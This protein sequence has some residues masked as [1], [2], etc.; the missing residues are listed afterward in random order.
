MFNIAQHGDTD[1]DFLVS[2]DTILLAPLPNDAE[3]MMQQYKI[4]FEAD[5]SDWVSMNDE[6][7]CYQP[8]GTTDLESGTFERK[9]DCPFIYS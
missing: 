9:Q 6:S 5:A 4:W 8:A 7:F 1:A 3:P 2:G